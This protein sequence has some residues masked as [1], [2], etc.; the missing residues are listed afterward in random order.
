M[1]QPTVMWLFIAGRVH[2]PL[3][4]MAGGRLDPAGIVDIPDF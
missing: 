2:I 4:G 3:L 1:Q